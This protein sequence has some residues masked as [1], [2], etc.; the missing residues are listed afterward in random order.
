MIELNDANFNDEVLEYR[1]KVIVDCW[2]TWCGICRMLKPKFEELES[3]HT[4]Y[5]FC[6]MDAD[7]APNI[8]SKYTITNIPTFLIF[9]NGKLI[10][11]GTY[12]LLEEL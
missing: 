7:K 11:Q 4:D 1:G 8:I 10:K 3:K 6:T 2:A 9:E 5:K 12:Q